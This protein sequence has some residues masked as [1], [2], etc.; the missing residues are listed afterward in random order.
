MHDDAR[1]LSRQLADM[2]TDARKR[3][4]ELVSDLT[5]GQMM[6]PKLRIVNPPL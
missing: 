2:L 1:D 3:T 6:G 5:D 4:L